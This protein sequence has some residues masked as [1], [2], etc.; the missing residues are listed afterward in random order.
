MRRDQVLKLCANHRITADLK[1]EAVNEK[2]WRWFVQDY[3]EPEAKHEILIAK[4]R[5]EDEAKRFKEEFDK[6]Q[7]AL[8][9]GK[10]VVW[11]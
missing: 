6:A 7:K 4:F 5:H 3:S 9:T 10:T 2:Q 8:A 11:H 1:L